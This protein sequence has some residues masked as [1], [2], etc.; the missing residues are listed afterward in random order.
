[1]AAD[2]KR[3]AEQLR[4]YL[5]C[6]EGDTPDEVLGKTAAA[7]E[8]GV[9]AVQLRVKSWTGRECYNTALALK[10]LCHVHGAAL[11]VNDRL[12]IA[13]AAGADGV[14]LGQKD[15]PVGAARQ[16]AGPDFIIGGTARTPEFAREAQRLGADYIGCGAAFGTTTKDDA[17]VIGPEGIKEVLAAVEIP[18]VAIGGIELANVSQ[19]AGCGCSGISLSGAVMRAADPREAAKALMREIDKSFGC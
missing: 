6:G 9:T 7:L 16:I 4:L 18:S 5:I 1:M 3:L 11:L 13:L 17:V 15:L 14:H 12:D 10:D 19:L 2:R 8:G